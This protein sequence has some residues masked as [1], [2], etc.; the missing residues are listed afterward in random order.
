MI[1]SSDYGEVWSAK[2]RSTSL[3]CAI[4][5]V[6]VI[7]ESF[8]LEN[9]IA[10]LK[11]CD[12]PFLVKYYGTEKNGNELWVCFDAW[13]NFQIIMEHFN[14]GSLES[15][16]QNGNHLKEDELKEIASCCLLGLNYL[17][18]TKIIAHQVGYELCILCIEC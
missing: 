17:H 14:C 2:N 5:K 12:S 7:N 10:V 16:I 9:E 8:P 1:I 6:N 4:R 11:S 18:N 3:T 15:Y 13:Y